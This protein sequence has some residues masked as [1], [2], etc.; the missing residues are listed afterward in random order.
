[1]WSLVTFLVVPVLAF[2]G[3]GPVSAMRRST[4]LFRQRWGQQVTGN[5]VIGGVAGLIVFAGLVVGLGGVALI[6]EGGT[7]AIAAG[8]LL[9]LVGFI[10]TLGGAVFAGATRSVFGVALYR[11]VAE[12]RA[13]G[14]FTATSSPAPHVSLPRRW[15]AQISQRY[16]PTQSA[17]KVSTAPPFT[18]AP[19]S[20]HR[21]V[22]GVAY[23]VHH[24]QL[25]AGSACRRRRRIRHHCPDARPALCHQYEETPARLRREFPDGTDAVA[26]VGSSAGCCHNA[27]GH[28]HSGSLH[29]PRLAPSSTWYGK[30]YLPKRQST[31]PAPAQTRP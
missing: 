10:A 30:T 6:I 31:R 23:W 14:P 1:M 2:E 24:L 22:S 9:L 5:V 19:R 20:S 21:T 16:N 15:R 18:S 4:E 12:D 11:H 27:P 17:I 13:L 25:A 26:Q 3:I 8:V 7:G 29:S 28:E